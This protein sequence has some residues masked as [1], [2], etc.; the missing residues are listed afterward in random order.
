MTSL[1]LE[2][3]DNQLGMLETGGE[4]TPPLHPTLYHPGAE[5][6]RQTTPRKREGS[7]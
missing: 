3:L 5:K 6:Q 1:L 4:M 2:H 7:P